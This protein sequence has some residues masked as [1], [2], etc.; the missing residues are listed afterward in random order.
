MKKTQKKKVKKNEEE[1][2]K[3]R[4]TKPPGPF[5]SF[6]FF[7]VSKMEKI[8]PVSLFSTLFLFV[9]FRTTKHY[10]I[11]TTERRNFEGGYK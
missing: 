8:S 3:K 6:S 10:V 5:F 7:F 9:F 2:Q 11:I 4:D 1:Q